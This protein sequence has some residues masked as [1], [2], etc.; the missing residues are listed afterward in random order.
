MKNIIITASL[1]CS[2]VANAQKGKD[3]PKIE[4]VT[5][6]NKEHQLP[7]TN[8]KISI[9]AIAFNKD[10]E[11]ELKKWLNPL[12]NTFM[13][14]SKATKGMD[15]STNYDVNFFFVPLIA[16][17]KVIFEK[18][19]ATTDKGFWPYVLDTRKSDIKSVATLLGVTD[20]KIP[21]IFILD[22]SGK[23]L[24]FQ[25]GEYSEDKIEAMEEVIE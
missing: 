13:V 25:T 18:F 17:L 22:K 4:G 12:Y 9:V 7:I 24:D 21:Y 2:L 3:F 5:L 15:L 11:D 1:F 19:Q 8:G 16:G 6:D 20:R 23:V 10:A 14:E